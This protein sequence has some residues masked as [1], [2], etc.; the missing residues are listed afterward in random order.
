MNQSA[1]AERPIFR[2]DANVQLWNLH[3]K[4]SQFQISVKKRGSFD[5]FWVAFWPSCLTDYGGSWHFLS[6]ETD[7]LLN[8]EISDIDKK[9]EKIEKIVFLPIL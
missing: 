5:E 7:Q 4:L 3:E 9:Q 6:F 8:F 1:R 2:T